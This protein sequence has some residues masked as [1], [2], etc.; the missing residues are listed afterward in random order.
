MS[1]QNVLRFW[2]DRGVSGFR[3]DAVPHIFEVEKDANGNYPDEPL[4]GN[5]NDPNDWNYLNH[6][7]TKDMPETIEMI[8]QWREVLD[9]HKKQHGGESR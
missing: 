9:N 4:S 1:F 8:Y 2:L 7:Y 6:I 5:T 3:I